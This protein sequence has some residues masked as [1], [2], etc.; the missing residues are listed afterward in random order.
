MKEA[1]NDPTNLPTTSSQV[2]PVQQISPVLLLPTL[3]APPV[4][5]LSALITPLTRGIHR[6]I[7]TL[8]KPIPL[9][10]VM[11]YYRTEHRALVVRRDAADDDTIR[12]GRLVACESAG[13]EDREL[14]ER[15]LGVREGEVLVVYPRE[16]V[17]QWGRV[18]LV[19]AAVPL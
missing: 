2:N 16:L 4:S 12:A 3:P 6:I 9:A 5:P 8:G 18:Q 1:G 10:T 19:G 11:R 7:P 17:L 15:L 13:L 14:Q